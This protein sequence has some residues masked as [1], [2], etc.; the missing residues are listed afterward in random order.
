MYRPLMEGKVTMTELKTVVTFQDL[1]EINALLDMKQ[2]M[3]QHSRDM[4]KGG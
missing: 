2:D 3:E 1:S 4:A